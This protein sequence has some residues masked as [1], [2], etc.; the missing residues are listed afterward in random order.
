[1]NWRWSAL[2]RYRLVSNSDAHSP[3]Q[4]RPGGEPLRHRAELGRRGRR[5][6]HRPR[7]PGH[8]RVLSRGGQVSP[9]RPPQM[10]R[11]HGP[12]ADAQGTA[13]CVPSAARR[14]PWACS[15]GCSRWRT[16]RTGRSRGRAKA[17]APSFPCPSCSPSWRAAGTGRGPSARCTRASSPRSAASTRFLLDVPVE[18]IARSHGALLAEA[19]RRMR[20]GRIDPR[21]GYDGEFGVIRVFDDAELTRLRG[22]DEL[23]PLAP[24]ACGRRAADRRE[25]PPAGPTAVPAPRPSPADVPPDLDAE[26]RAIVGWRGAPQPRRRGA[27]HGKDAAAGG[28]D[29]AH[30]AQVRRSPGRV[31]ALTFTNRAAGRA[32]QTARR[33][34]PAGRGSDVTASTFHS[35]CWSVLRERDPSLPFGVHPLAAGRAAGSAVPRRRARRASAA[36]AERMEQVLGR[37][38]GAG[39]GAAAR[40]GRLRG[41]AAADRRRGCLVP[42]QR[43]SSGCFAADDGAPR[44]MCARYRPDR[45]G[46]A[47]GHQQAA[48]RAPADPVRATAEAVLCIGDPDQAIYGFRGSDRKLFFRFAEATGARTFR[49]RA[50]T[51]RW[52]HRDGGG[53]RDLPP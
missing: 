7:F 31:L 16:G 10:R 34:A 51:V 44:G 2:D 6:A 32:A 5:P 52:S 30:G 23:F 43:G 8:L 28:L 4:P 29:R 53:G 26:Q 36:A 49:L 41:G 14:S 50:T 17:S 48:V 3:R 42:G 45:R 38:G 20:E 46:R 33:P 12:G 47:P 22:Q 15:A 37:D 25:A 9:R 13:A 19:V 21:P 1:M 27:R 11:L 24:R 39:R 35:F 40:H 18:D